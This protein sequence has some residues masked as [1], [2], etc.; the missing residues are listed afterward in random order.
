MITVNVTACGPVLDVVPPVRAT[1]TLLDPVGVPALGVGGEAVAHPLRKGIRTP[2]RRRKTPKDLPLRRQPT[3]GSRQIRI[4][5]AMELPGPRIDA[6]RHG[7]RWSIAD[8]GAVVMIV[9]WVVTGP[10]FGVTVFG[11]NVHEA[12]EGKPAQER[13]VAWL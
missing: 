13:L 5:R 2:A 8:V 1:V 3:G 9:N 12:S 4:P 7:L 6:G 10:P 11:V